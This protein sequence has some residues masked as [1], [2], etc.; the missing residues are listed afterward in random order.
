MFLAFISLRSND[1]FDSEPERAILL[2]AGA[3]FWPIYR[4][5]DFSQLVGPLIHQAPSVA[6]DFHQ[7]YLTR[8]L[9]YFRKEVGDDIKMDY[10]LWIRVKV[11]T[12][13]LAQDVE[14]DQ[15]VNKYEQGGSTVIVSC[16][17]T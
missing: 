13:P 6:L 2:W 1:W 7:S 17:I 11:M 16:H 10:I 3:Q 5:A 9:T 12:S 15:T 14:K 4:S 8:Q